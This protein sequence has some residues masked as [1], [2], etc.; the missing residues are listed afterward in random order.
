M[1]KLALEAKSLDE[2]SI[3]TAVSKDEINYLFSKSNIELLTENNI[4]FIAS[5]A[6]STKDK[7]FALFNKQANSVDS[8]MKSKSYSR[9]I[10]DKILINEDI[11]PL[12][13][14]GNADWKQINKALT[15]KYD[16]T[17][18]DRAITKAK[19]YSCYGKDW[20]EFTAALVHY[21]DEYE[22]KANL[23]LLDKNARY[24]LQHSQSKREMQSALTWNELTLAEQPGNKDFIATNAAL[25]TKLATIN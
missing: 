4:R 3:A 7:G 17:I 23:K 24:V 11:D 10:V 2:D 9:D 20:Q 19:I 15:E 25:K 5:F 8:V 6:A 21:T 16:A 13:Q 12:R 14:N 1:Y 22:D 18:A